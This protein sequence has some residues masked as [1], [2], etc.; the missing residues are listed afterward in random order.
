[1]AFS[2]SDNLFGLSPYI[3]DNTDAAYYQT[4]GA[5]IAQAV[6][7]GHTFGDP[8]VVFIRSGTYVEDVVL[9]SGIFLQGVT[10]SDPFAPRVI[11]SGSVTANAVGFNYYSIQNLTINNPV[12][13]SLILTGTAPMRFIGTDLS[14]SFTAANSW[15]ID[16]N[17]NSGTFGL[18][19]I[20]D[21][22]VNGDD[23]GA[24]IVNHNTLAISRT[25]IQGNNLAG[26]NVANTSRIV[27]NSGSSIGSSGGGA[28]GLIVSDIST[29]LIEYTAIPSPVF[30]NDTTNVQLHY[31]PIDAGAAEAITIAAGATCEVI[32]NIINS[33]AASGFWVT[34]PGTVATGGNNTLTGT[35]G[36]IDPGTTITGYGSG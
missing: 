2:N 19:L 33:S 30:C 29:A 28:S 36:L 27:A 20:Y 22:Q 13:N 34:G 6:A 4:I 8:T 9:E 11:I 5:A 21:C 26:V 23:Y 18:A 7:D 31:C 25:T 14:I 32:A 15:G 1:M 24:N 35:A 17:C 3:V 10:D 16:F 12:G